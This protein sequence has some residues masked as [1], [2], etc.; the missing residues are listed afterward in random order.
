M[1][2]KLIKHE[3]RATARVML[4]LFLVVVVTALGANV[5]QNF[6]ETGNPVLNI[7]GTL[8][9]MG[10]VLAIMAVCIVAFLLMLQRFY[11]NLLQDEGY[12][13]HTLPVSVHQLVCSKLLVSVVWTLLTG[14]IVVISFGIM[15]YEVGLVR[16][17]LYVIGDLLHALMQLGV[18][19]EVNGAL[20]VAELAV[21]LFLGCMGTC[22]QFYAAMSMGHSISNYK[23]LW[24]ILIYFGMQFVEQLVGSVALVIMGQT[25]FPLMFFDRM[26]Q[27]LQSSNSIMAAAHLGMSIGILGTLAYCVLFYFLTTFF[28]KK[29]LNLE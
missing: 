24:S 3:F 29:H 10:Y 13:M 1:L 16:E 8:L 7:L 19:Y 12:V 21:L 23:L 28:L 22:L 27:A 4:P 5:A 15:A 6:L 2:S 20:F 14:V 9:L 26:E 11:R 18:S 25:Q 17:S